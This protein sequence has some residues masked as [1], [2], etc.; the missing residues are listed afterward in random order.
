MKYISTVAIV[1]LL[2][3]NSL[4][5]NTIL[6]QDFNQGF[7]AGWSLIDNDSLT[8]NS[9]PAVNFITDAFV[10]AEDADS[11]SMGDSLLVAT[12]WFDTTGTADDY[13]ILPP[14]TMGA[15]GNYISFDAKS[16][17]HTHPNGLEVL[18]SAGGINPWDFFV[19]PSAYDT[20]I[21]PP[22]WTNYRVSLDSVGISPG[23]TVRIAFRHYSTDQYILALD[24]I[25]VDIDDDLSNA[26]MDLLPITLYP[27]PVKEGVLNINLIA[28]RN[29]QIFD[30]QGKQVQN[31]ICFKQIHLDDLQGGLYLLNIVGYKTERFIVE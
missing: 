15:Y 9:S 2:S 18:V 24:N 19:L 13:L 5:Q 27:N 25:K 14:L 20:F 22:Y 11:T 6:F 10:I 16:M 31:G 23:Q 7:P 28:N 29:Y 4:A 8:P 17:D 1:V 3:L 21:T 30:A 12:S 26:E